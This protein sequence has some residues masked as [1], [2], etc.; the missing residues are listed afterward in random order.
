MPVVETYR[1]IS[2]STALGSFGIFSS[3][4]KEGTAMCICA[5]GY[6]VVV[7]SLVGAAES[8][9]ADGFFEGLMDRATE[10]AKRKAQDE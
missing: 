3:A 5:I 9:A 8:K 6:L 2:N 4:M 1:L 10:G 7:L